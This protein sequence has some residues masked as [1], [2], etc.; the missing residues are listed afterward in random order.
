MR[1]LI[2]SLEAEWRRY[3]T[4]GEGAIQQ[5]RDD[6]LGRDSGGNSVAVI[7]WHVAGNLK[8]RFTDF[9]TTDGEKPWRHRE[10]EFDDRSK[11]T[12]TELLEKWNSGWNVLLKTLETLTDEDLMRSVSIRGVE[13]RVHDALHRSVAHTSYH[14]GQIVILAKGFRRSE[15]KSLSIPK[16]KSEQYNQNP[17]PARE[18]PSKA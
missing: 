2:S 6:E 18:R 13:C 16:G 4:L 11:I 12:R 17:D 9:L 1:E 15:W 5:V 14:V 10:S 8:S 3:K 7:V